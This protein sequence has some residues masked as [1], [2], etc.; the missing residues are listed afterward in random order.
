M[1]QILD[2]SKYLKSKGATKVTINDIISWN[3]KQYQYMQLEKEI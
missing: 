2:L 3:G 1:N